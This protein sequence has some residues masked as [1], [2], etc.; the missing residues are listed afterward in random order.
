MSDIFERMLAGR[1][2]QNIDP[3]FHKIFKQVTDTKNISV[4][5]NLASDPAEIRAPILINQN[6]WIG[7]GAIILPDVN[8]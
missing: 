4:S 5:L 6:A 3:K 1:V 7:T 8:K 2:V